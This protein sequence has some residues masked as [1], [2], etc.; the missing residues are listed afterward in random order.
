MNVFAKGTCALNR[1]L[2]SIHCFNSVDGYQY[3]DPIEYDDIYTDCALIQ[4][5]GDCFELR[6][7]DDGKA[8]FIP[9]STI[10]PD[11]VKEEA[12]KKPIIVRLM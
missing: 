12:K 7:G 3:V 5:F 9:Y 2:P 4:V 6:V 10:P 1:G 11:Q 8:F